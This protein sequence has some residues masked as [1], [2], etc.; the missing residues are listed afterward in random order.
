[1]EC[2]NCF[3]EAQDEFTAVVFET[4]W[5]KE[6]RVK[7]FCSEDCMDDYLYGGDFSYFTCAGCER[8]ICRQNPRN[9]WHVQSR[10]VDG[11]EICLKCYEEEVLKNGVP[12]EKFENNRIPGMFFSYGNIE[13]REAGFIEVEGFINCHI[14]GEES[15]RRLCQK[16]LELIEKG[17]KVVV[18]YESMGIG[19]V[20]GY[21]TLM[22]RED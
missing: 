10:F 7:K 14:T 2:L 16:A 15:V 18:G 5:D 9:G 8:E 17:Y 6:P 19:G 20:E 3:E 1:M 22:K 21:V 11:E 13:P 12:K 4:P